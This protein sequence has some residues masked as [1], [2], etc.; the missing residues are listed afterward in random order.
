VAAS[1]ATGWSVSGPLCPHDHGAGVVID[2]RWH[3][4]EIWELTHAVPLTEAEKAHWQPERRFRLGDEKDPQAPITRSTA[5]GRLQLLLERRWD[6]SRA[7]YADGP[8]G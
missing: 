7:A 2:G 3:R 5:N 1:E 8:R 4:L 6:G